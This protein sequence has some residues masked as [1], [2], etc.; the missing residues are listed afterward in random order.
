MLSEQNSAGIDDIVD[1]NEQTSRI[2]DDMAGSVDNN[3]GN[4][5]AL[6]DIISKFTLNR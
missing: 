6:G 4:A 3:K 2:A 5:K 1:K